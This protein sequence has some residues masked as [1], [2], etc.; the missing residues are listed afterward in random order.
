MNLN[1]PRPA[2]AAGY[3]VAMSG[4]RKSGL[5]AKGPFKGTPID[6]LK[7]SFKGSIG[8]PLKASFT[9]SFRGSFRSASK[10]SFE[11][12]TVDGQNPAL[13]IIRNIP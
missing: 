8:V 13:P 11:G 9:G 4:P 3:V 7:G 1:F 5:P 12:S 10:G 6:P 2:F